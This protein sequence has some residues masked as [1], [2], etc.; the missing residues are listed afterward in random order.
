MA[1]GLAVALNEC[2]LWPLKPVDDVVNVS[3]WNCEAYRLAVSAERF[4][5]EYQ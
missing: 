4:G 1:Q 3:C 2:E 5:L